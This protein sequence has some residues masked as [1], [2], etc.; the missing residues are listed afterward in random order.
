MVDI[1]Q[2]V[3]ARVVSRQ[4]RARVK[5]QSRRKGRRDTIHGPTII[6][7]QREAR[8][9]KVMNIMRSHQDLRIST[10]GDLHLTLNH[11]DMV[12]II[13]MIDIGRDQRIIRQQEVIIH[14]PYLIAIK[15]VGQQ[16]EP[17]ARGIRALQRD[18]VV[19]DL[20]VLVGNKT[21]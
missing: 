11:M 17:I 9:S 20:I 8:D 10:L 5:R 19:S 7:E 16:A 4:R 14:R 15:G 6:K 18:Q 1:D 3:K 2:V 21:K 13:T 12:R